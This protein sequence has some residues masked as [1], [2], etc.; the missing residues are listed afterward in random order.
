MNIRRITV[1]LV[2]AL[3]V[4]FGYPGRLSV[5]AHA[6]SVNGIS[7]SD[8]DLEPDEVFSLSINIPALANADTATLKIGFDPDTFEVTSDVTSWQ[9]SFGN[10]IAVSDAGVIALSAANDSS[11]IDLSRGLTLSA[12]LRVKSTAVIGDHDIILEKSS[13]SV[14]DGANST[15]LWTPTATAVTVKVRAADTYP[16]TYG[17]IDLSKK[18]VRA[19]ETFTATINIPVFSDYADTATL[20]VEFD[21]TAFEVTSWAP[22]IAGGEYHSGEGFFSVSASND[23]PA[24]DL[25][26]GLTLSA[27]MKA[28]SSVSTGDSPFTLTKSSISFV[29]TDGITSV[30]MWAPTRT[31]A[32]IKAI[33]TT[34]TP[35]PVV[36][37]TGGGITVSGSSFRPNEEFTVSVVIPKMVSADTMTIKVEFNSSIFE[38]T[39]WAPNV[40]GGVSDKGSGYFALSASN[41][42]RSISLDSGKTLTA[43]LKV[44]SNAAVGNYYFSLTK[45]SISYVDESDGYTYIQ[46][47]APSSKS[48]SVSVSS[49][50][51]Y[52][53]TGGGLSLSRS[54]IY[55]GDSFVVYINIPAI[56]KYAD[57]L[58]VRCEY[59]R[60]SFELVSW[61]PTITGGT[62][63]YGPGYFSLSASNNRNIIDVGRGLTFAATLRSRYGLNTGSYRFDITYSSLTYIK[64]NNRERQELWQPTNTTAYLRVIYYNPAVTNSSNNNN[65]PAITTSDA[66][67]QNTNVY[68]DD[69]IDED[70][71]DNDDI[72]DDTTK[73]ANK[74]T[75]ESRL[76]DL[77]SGS[78]RTSTKRRFFYNDTF[79]ILQ[80]TDEADKMAVKAL[81]ALGMSGHEYYVFDISLYDT[82]TGQYLRSL[83]NNGYV[84]FTLPLPKKLHPVSSAIGVYHIENGIPEYVD[85]SIIVE[86]GQE[87]ICF[88]A[89]SFSPYMFVDTING[90]DATI[91]DTDDHTLPDNNN[92]Y[93]GGGGSGSSNGYSNPG[94]GVAAAVII[95]AA[96]TGCLLLGRKNKHHR[97]RTK[98]KIE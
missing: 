65:S 49:S 42:E 67:N 94:T 40:P 98:T 66:A 32:N 61:S 22:V 92:S 35:T 63:S 76:S 78:V 27:E 62:S 38:V 34:P 39:E 51:S 2:F 25:T 85:S 91:T 84:K 41:A 17:G 60:N 33:G 11:V 81:R 73:S 44:K 9:S 72:D 93:G 28:K 21:R 16:R 80:N 71:T 12:S 86:N 43:K 52:P 14:T 48:A 88:K 19:G 18:E 45:S 13:L 90:K 15:E 74:I 30:E 97:K 7:V 82:A 70:D 3:F 59:D 26:R 77:D 64:D 58:S 56:D 46:L 50:S 79:I 89:Y 75:L 23:T 4:F 83:K 69:P 24:I 36:P 96:L 6:A 55:S 95:P 47:W 87:F 53:V 68:F 8:K 1:C 10:C 54:E 57:I 20:K 5:P 37:A 31:T 29:G